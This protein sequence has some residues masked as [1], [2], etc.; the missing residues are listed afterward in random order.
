M[1]KIRQKISRAT[2]A[3]AK[4]KV[5]RPLAYGV[6][7]TLTTQKKFYHLSTLPGSKMNDGMLGMIDLFKFKKKN[8]KW[9]SLIYVSKVERARPKIKKSQKV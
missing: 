5:N 1:P 6:Q 9:K 3:V 8:G 4:V 7:Y 2:G